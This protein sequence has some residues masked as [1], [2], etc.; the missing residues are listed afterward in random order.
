LRDTVFDANVGVIALN[1]ERQCVQCIPRCLALML[2]VAH[3]I[4]FGN[5]GIMQFAF[6]RHFECFCT[7]LPLLN[8]AEGCLR[9]PSVYPR[10]KR[11]R[12]GQSAVFCFR[13]L[14]LRQ[15]DAS[16]FEDF[17][18]GWEYS[19]QID[20]ERFERCLLVLP[21]RGALHVAHLKAVRC[22]EPTDVGLGMCVTQARQ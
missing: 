3:D 2:Q 12:L 21:Q 13:S 14:Y 15:A 18:A 20:V 10:R 5:A 4:G 19:I 17:D 22:A 6:E 8:P 7:S 9:L 1:A 16:A 11:R